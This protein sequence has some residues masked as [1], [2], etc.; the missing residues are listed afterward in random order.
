MPSSSPRF[1]DIVIIGAGAA[2]ITV[3]SQLRAQAPDLDILLIEPSATHHY[4]PGWTLVGGG[5][6]P[7]EETARPQRNCLPLGVTWLQD[8][9]AELAPEH[10]QVVTAQGLQI[11]YGQLVVCPGLQI[12][13]DKIEG[14]TEALGRD[15]VASNYAPQ[16]AP[17][18][19]ECLQNFRGGQALFTHPATPIKCGGAPQKIMYLADDVFQQKSGVGSRTRVSFY[20]AEG[21]LFGVPEY[22]RVLEGVA[23]RRRI[24]TKFRHNL[25][26][27][28]GRRREAVFEQKTDQGV[29]QVTVAYDFIHVTPP[30]GAPDFVA[31][32]PLG[33]AGSG[34]LEVDLHT[35][36][37]LRYENVFGLGDVAHLPTSKTAAAVRGQAPVVVQNLLALRR[38]EAPTARYDG[39]TCCPVITGYNSAVMAEFNY[40]KKP[41]SSFY[42]NP[43]QERYSMWLAK[44]YLLPWLYWNR[45]LKGAPF[46]KEILD[47][48]KA[49]L[50]PDAAETASPLRSPSAP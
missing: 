18:T 33:K 37:H 27:L 2:G 9:V 49:R 21:S 17:Y 11:R 16:G 44:R 19:W 8:Q 41:I 32:S 1:H 42:L 43:T 29:E 28:D 5:L 50:F 23:E 34:W 36:Q 13:W 40:E 39:Y 31:Q 4:Q 45:M 25:V 6:L 30:M 38:G 46:E 10:N 26:A 14:L 35:L 3:A 47:Q 22:A 24:E 48:W 12:N 20:S 15:G 7:F